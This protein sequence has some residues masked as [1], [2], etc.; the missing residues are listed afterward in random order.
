MSHRLE[1]GL[2][3]PATPWLAIEQDRIDD[4]AAATEDRA[5]AAFAA[6][7]GSKAWSRSPAAGR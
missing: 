2:E 6:A 5:A 4:F 7:S 1:A 3:L